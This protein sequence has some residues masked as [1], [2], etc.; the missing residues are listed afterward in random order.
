[1]LCSPFIRLCSMDEKSVTSGSFYSVPDCVVEHTT[2]YF[3]PSSFSFHFLVVVLSLN[4]YPDIR[5]RLEEEKKK[6]KKKQR[7]N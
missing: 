6:K 5:R 2:V 1:M 4:D 3:P 7:K